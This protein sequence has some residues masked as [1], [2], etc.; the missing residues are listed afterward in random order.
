MSIA[1]DMSAAKCRTVNER[2]IEKCEC[3]G[4]CNVCF[5]SIYP[6]IRLSEGMR[7]WDIG[8]G[9]NQD[10]AQ[11]LVVLGRGMFGY[12]A[13]KPRNGVGRSVNQL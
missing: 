2:A 13:Q 5:T 9:Q 3:S 1:P 11:R 8:R 6:E 10:Y 12:I 4:Q 7:T